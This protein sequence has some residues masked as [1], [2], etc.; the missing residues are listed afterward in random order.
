MEELFRR[1]G[2]AEALFPEAR[3]RLKTAEEELRR[4]ESD[5]V[6]AEKKLSEAESERTLARSRE[7]AIRERSTGEAEL[8][9]Q[10]GLQKGQEGAEALWPALR[11][12]PGYEA[13]I[14][15]AL[16]PVLDGGYW[17]MTLSRWREPWRRVMGVASGILLSKNI[18]PERSHDWTE[19][20]WNFVEGAPEW[21][22]LLHRLLADTCVTD[23]WEEAKALQASRP[24]ATVICRDG[25]MIS[26]KGWQRR[27]KVRN[28]RPG[29]Q[30]C[31]AARELVLRLDQV[32]A[33][34]TTLV[35][36]VRNRIEK[37]REHLEASRSHERQIRQS[38]DEVRREHDRK[39]AQVRSLASET[40]RRKDEATRL[41]QEI[42]VHQKIAQEKNAEA[43]RHLAAE[44]TLD[45]EMQ[46]AEKC[47]QEAESAEVRL[48]DVLT[49]RR[50]ERSAQQ[51][52]RDSCAAQLHPAEARRKELADLVL[53]RRDEISADTARMES[54]RSESHSSAQ[55][56]QVASQR[57]KEIEAST[58]G[59]KQARENEVSLL[60]EK[61]GEVVRWRQEGEKAKDRLAELAVK[62][63]QLDF[64]RQSLA[65]RLQ[66]E[67][68]T[69]LM[70]AKSEG[71]GLPQTEEEWGKLEDEAKVFTGKNG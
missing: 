41:E 48:N 57:A 60:T 67:Y 18:S 71:D 40:A 54:A 34:A 11:I 10:V 66:R 50:V 15:L 6:D 33:D 20:A 51:Q 37:G 47:R 32:T 62:S 70:E 28:S 19:G 30:E 53:K 9:L 49:D 39:E 69:P 68:A 24:E 59:L 27:G 26:A 46:G 23:T 31:E 52:R 63:S 65:D 12:R 29:R 58:S 44:Q 1:L 7:E 45:Q 43:A 56:Q 25:R 5:L 2:E 55:A 3:D 17:F 4:A 14:S 38:L 35:G 16:G 36:T 13:A 42:L 61:E 64:Q 21:Q 8:C 22:P